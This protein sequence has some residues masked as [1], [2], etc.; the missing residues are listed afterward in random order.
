[1]GV[2]R[3]DVSVRRVNLA[4]IALARAMLGG[5]MSKI[6]KRMLRARH[7][8]K[9]PAVYSGG[10]ANFYVRFY[11][12]WKQTI[13]WNRQIEEWVFVLENVRTGKERITRLGG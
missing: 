7:W 6:V 12:G 11:H 2:W 8:V 13:V 5:F 10:K 3:F 1:M 4:S 9:C